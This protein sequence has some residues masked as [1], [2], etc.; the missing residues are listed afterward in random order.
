MHWGV[1]YADCILGQCGRDQLHAICV[2]LWTGVS[3]QRVNAVAGHYMRKYGQTEARLRFENQRRY[4]CRRQLPNLAGL[5]LEAGFLRE[6]RC[7]RR[8]SP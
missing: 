3:N 4:D 8:T 1:L 6:A 5:A 7:D 2:N